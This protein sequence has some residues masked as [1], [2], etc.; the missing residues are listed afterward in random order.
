MTETNVSPAI[1]ESALRNHPRNPD[2]VRL[3]LAS[4]SRHGE[5]ARLISHG[6]IYL[7]PSNGYSNVIRQAVIDAIP[8]KAD[9]LSSFDGFKLLRF[10]LTDD[11]EDIRLVTAETVH[12]VLSLSDLSL[13]ATLEALHKFASRK[14]PAEYQ[15]W[16]ESLSFSELEVP[17]SSEFVLFDAEPQNLFVRPSWEKHIIHH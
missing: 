3:C 8:T 11:D 6:L 10:G 7:E 5:F 17:S 4:L 12:A 9:L 14:W 16:L 1:V 2:I 15:D 13:P